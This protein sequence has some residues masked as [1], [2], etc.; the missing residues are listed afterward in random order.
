MSY[1]LFPIFYIGMAIRE[2][3]F[4]AKVLDCF[5]VQKI[6]DFSLKRNPHRT[7]HI[8]HDQFYIYM[9][10]INVSTSLVVDVS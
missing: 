10:V 3:A 6:L 4:E 1:N 8:D 2:L 9:V 7:C 5:H